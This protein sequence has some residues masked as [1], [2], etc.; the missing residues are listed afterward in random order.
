MTTVKTRLVELE[1]RR[2]ILVETLAGSAAPAPRL[3]PRLA[4]VYR[5][6]LAALIGALE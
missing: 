6:K 2:D 1:S 4:D 5:D 3:H